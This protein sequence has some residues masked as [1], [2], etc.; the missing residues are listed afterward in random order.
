MYRFEKGLIVEEILSNGSTLK[1]DMKYWEK[2]NIKRYYVT[3][4]GEQIGWIS[5]DYS[6]GQ[7]QRSS[8]NQTYINRMVEALKENN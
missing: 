2:G 8:T 7:G 4:A 1:V 5:A 3:R 6:S